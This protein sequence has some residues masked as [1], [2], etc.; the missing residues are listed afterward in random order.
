VASA[1]Q[2]VLEHQGDAQGHATLARIHG[3]AFVFDTRLLHAQLE[4]VSVTDG[5]LVVTKLPLPLLSD[6]AYQQRASLRPD[7]FE[8]RRF[9]LSDLGLPSSEEQL[10][11][12]GASIASY[13]R[14]L[15]IDETQ[16]SSH[17]GLAF[18]LEHAARLVAPTDVTS[19]LA[20]CW[21]EL[22]IAHDLRAY[23]L[24][25]ADDVARET[26]PGAPPGAHPLWA[27]P[28][29]Q[30]GRAYVRLVFARGARDA[31]ETAKIADIEASLKLLANKLPFRR[32]ARLIDR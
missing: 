25:V 30:A 6:E 2:Y 23:E 3:L 5:E 27:L 13:E 9:D 28:S 32:V 29:F 16:A 19:L 10:A 15:A 26:V 11:H 14:A 20:G 8:A 1:E 22:A 17:L 4:T 21:R 18:V 7:S 31:I 12:L 24:A